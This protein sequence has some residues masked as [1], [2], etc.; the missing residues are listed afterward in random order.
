MKSLLIIVFVVVGITA[1]TQIGFNSK[2]NNLEIGGSLNTPILSGFF[3]TPNYKVSGENLNEVKDLIDLGLHFSY[4]HSL[5]N[6]FALGLFLGAKQYNISVGSNY[7]LF[8]DI[9]GGISGVDSFAVRMENLDFKNYYVGP[10]FEFSSKNGTIGIGLGYDF[11]F[12][13]SISKLKNRSYAY[14]LNE[15]YPLEEENWSTVDYYTM[16]ADWKPFY[17]VFLRTGFKMS[18]PITD[19]LAF[20]SG[21][22]YSINYTLKPQD[23]KMV[24]NPDK[25]IFN[26]EDIYYSIQ[27]ENLG[28]IQLDL[29]FTFFF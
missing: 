28:M 26:Y 1:K 25:D 15:I 22:H 7:E 3:K 12:G 19:Y 9:G 8:Y 11:A 23:L 16:S 5:S 24:E 13:L 20:D 14:A 10:K 27:R 4:T 21:L 6:H 18:L 2:L 29:G 17:G